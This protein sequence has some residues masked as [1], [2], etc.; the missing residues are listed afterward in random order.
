MRMCQARGNTSTKGFMVDHCNHTTVRDM[1]I[2]H[3]GSFA[4]FQTDGSNNT[5]E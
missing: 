4:M 2:Y 1:T 5:F 3:A